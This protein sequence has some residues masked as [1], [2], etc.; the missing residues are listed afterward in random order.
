MDF[1]KSLLVYSLLLPMHWV[2]ILGFCF[3]ADFVLCGHVL[4]TDAFKLRQKQHMWC[5]HV[6]AVSAGGP[7]IRA[8]YNSLFLSLF[9]L[10]ILLHW[11]DEV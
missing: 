3:V 6:K 11:P 4:K 5:E 1:L 9:D 8:L 10:V 2:L 7:C